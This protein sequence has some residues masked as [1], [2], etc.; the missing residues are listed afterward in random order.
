MGSRFCCAI[1]QALL[2]ALEGPEFRAF[3][4]QLVANI[5]PQGSSV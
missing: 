5:A 3:T 2:T 4:D 1:L